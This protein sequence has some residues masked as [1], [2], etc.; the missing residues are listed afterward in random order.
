MIQVSDIWVGLYAKYEKLLDE[1]V[2]KTILPN[3]SVN[4]RHISMEGATREIVARFE[5]EKAR[6]EVLHRVNGNRITHNAALKGLQ[7]EFERELGA[8]V[9]EAK[10]PKYR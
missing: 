5:A 3:Y 4:P 6:L 10:P 9:R 2:A 7:N 1:Y 8:I